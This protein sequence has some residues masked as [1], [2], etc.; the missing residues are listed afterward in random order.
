MRSKLHR[1]LADLARFDHE[2]GEELDELARRLNARVARLLSLIF[3]IAVVAASLSDDWLVRNDEALRI[4][5]AWRLV[6]AMMGV[7]A[8][9]V[10]SRVLDRRAR[11]MPWLVG[12]GLTATVVTAY[13]M[14]SVERIVHVGFLHGALLVPF[15]V[16]FLILPLRE[17]VWL[18]FAV[19]GA[20]AAVFVA[21]SPETIRQGAGRAVLLNVGFSVFA[22]IATGHVLQRLVAA[23][24]AQRR[25]LRTHASELESRV[26]EATARLRRLMQHVESSREDERMRIARELH[27]ETSQVL[28]GMRIE[29]A[30]LRRA[31]REDE[32]L[33][34]SLERLD[35]LVEASI[36]A[37]SNIIRSL[38]PLALDD[39]D[40]GD[41]LGAQCDQ[42]RERTGL[43][44][45]L[46]VHGDDRVV[47]AVLITAIYRLVQE[48][49]TNVCRHAEA[50]RVAIEVGIDDDEL[51]VRVE[52]DGC[53]FDLAEVRPDSFGLLGM[54]ERISGLGGTIEVRSGLGAGTT[55]EAR[56]S[57]E[58]PAALSMSDELRRA[59]VGPT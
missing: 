19:T 32:A 6:I 17:R 3:I 14:G 13:A 37:E 20:Y 56:L 1:W 33:L 29:L 52:D 55:I 41:A 42:V 44:I 26:Q 11:P 4:M 58:L 31:A 34:R 8:F 40:L 35:D 15:G 51:T 39:A 38:R 28:A 10:L 54:K 16:T 47:P 36:Q 25:A 23:T 43:D 9:V 18:T 22:A 48:A 30:I 49:L 57:T 2:D 24:Y 53:G 45:A 12:F 21:T 5:R 46:E 50:T 27:D 59:R 7:L